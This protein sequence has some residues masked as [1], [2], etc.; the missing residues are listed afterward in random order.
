MRS[1]SQAGLLA[2]WSSF[3]D[4]FGLWSTTTLSHN[5]FGLVIGDLEMILA[6]HFPDLLSPNDFVVPWTPATLGYTRDCAINNGHKSFIFTF[7][8]VPF[9]DRCL[10]S[11]QFTSS[12][13]SRVIFFFHL[14]IATNTWILPSFHC[15]SATWCPIFLPYLLKFHD[16]L[17]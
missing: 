7:S 2:G 9:L 4:G 12:S 10:S 15:P 17:L 8:S 13:T 3:L 14:N 5:T 11:F 1:K 6:S 16:Q